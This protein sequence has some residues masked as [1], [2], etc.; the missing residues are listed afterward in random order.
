MN[1]KKKIIK[2]T[3]YYNDKKEPVLVRLSKEDFDYF[4]KE[5]TKLSNAA[6]KI[7]TRKKG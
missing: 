1:K 2:P 7:V 3:F 6:K 5:L 4:Y